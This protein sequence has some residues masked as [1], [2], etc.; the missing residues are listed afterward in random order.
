M[1]IIHRDL[2]PSNLFLDDQ[3]AL[4]IAGFDSSIEAEVAMDM[5]GTPGYVA[6]EVTSLTFSGYKKYADMWSVGCIILDLLTLKTSRDV[7]DLLG[8]KIAERIESIPKYY[9]KKWP[10]IVQSLMIHDPNERISA[11]DLQVAVSN[12]QDDLFKVSLKSQN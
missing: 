3:D 11:L 6:P 12:I 7:G 1:K 5:I 10:G 8:T 2:K 4:K 9:S